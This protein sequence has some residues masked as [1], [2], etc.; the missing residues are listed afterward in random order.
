MPGTADRVRVTATTLATDDHDEIATTLKV[1][2]G[3]HVN[4]NP[5]SF[6][7]LIPTTVSF[8]GLS[9]T[10]VV[11]PQTVR[12]KPK[13]ALDGLDVYE[14][15]TKIVAIFPRGAL[16]PAGSIRGTLTVQACSDEVCLPPAKIPMMPK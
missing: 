7:Y 10:R 11:Y 13:F 3:W 16:K 9:A 2:P 6:D 8:E 14:G 1:D 4:A 15:V 5:A 12:I